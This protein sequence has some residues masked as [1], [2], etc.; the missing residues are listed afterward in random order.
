MSQKNFIP[1]SFFSLFFDD[2]WDVSKIH[3]K[4]SSTYKVAKNDIT[5]SGQSA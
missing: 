2:Y 4:N 5:V 3:Q 1:D